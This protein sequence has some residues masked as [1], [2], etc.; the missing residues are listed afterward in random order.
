MGRP[1]DVPRCLQ[2]EAPA[3]SPDLEINVPDE[4]PDAARVVYHKVG[5]ADAR[6]KFP[7]SLLR[8]SPVF[9]IL[10]STMRFDPQTARA[11]FFCR[12]SPETTCE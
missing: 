4:K 6:K 12:R 2:P 5:R 10:Y 8:I 11:A 9:L 3:L 7:N 1:F